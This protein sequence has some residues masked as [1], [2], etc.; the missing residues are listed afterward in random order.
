MDN[1][2]VRNTVAKLFSQDREVRLETLKEVSVADVPAYD[3]ALVYF[4]RSNPSIEEKIICIRSFHN[5]DREGVLECIE[6]ASSDDYYEVRLVAFKR[7]A[8]LESDQDLIKYS[9]I[10]LKGLL[11]S[12][13]E[14]LAFCLEIFQGTKFKDKLAQVIAVHYDQNETSSCL[15]VLF[16]IYELGLSD[17]LFVLESCLNHFE[18]S[19]RTYAKKLLPSYVNKFPHLKDLQVR[20]RVTTSEDIDLGQLSEVL[21]DKDIAKVVDYLIKMRKLPKE[22]LTNE[23]LDCLLVHL[24]DEINPFIIATIIKTLPCF[25]NFKAYDEICEFL[26]HE[27]QR[28]VANCV[29]C[30][31]EQDDKRVLEF[32]ALKIAHLDYSCK[33]DLRIIS[34]AMTV[35]RRYEPN[36]ALQ[37]MRG[38]TV[39]NDHAVYTYL[40]DVCSW[41][42]NQLLESMFLLLNRENRVRI[43]SSLC[44]YFRKHSDLSSFKQ[45]IGLINRTSDIEKRKVLIT[46][47]RELLDKYQDEDLPV[48]VDQTDPFYNDLLPSEKVK[49]HKR[50]IFVSIVGVLII[51]IWI[52]YI[53]PN[54][55]EKQQISK[56]VALFLSIGDKAKLNF[57][58]VNQDKQFFYVEY[59]GNYFQLLKDSHEDF[60][61]GD[62]VKAEVVY[63][64][65]T[66]FSAVK[67]LKVLSI[68]A[69]N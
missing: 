60:I 20:S 50:L 51:A 44:E 39:A 43:V 30:L 64:K 65:D 53:V 34:G 11:D 17:Q 35:L 26:L 12:H 28:V 37:Y 18:E 15:A 10:L 3:K 63:L 14:N 7:V 29:E 61:T 6:E 58:I 49:F 23:V 42:D 21:Q 24:R 46:C 62:I 31:S 56:P 40:H 57:K 48:I 22:T 38:L 2:I 47:Y 1:D 69:V 54:T 27:D 52:A 13:I 16:L 66:K 9:Y 68:Q 41:D 55:V 59:N 32:I 33:E 19:V 4:F 67:I 36:L 25:Q 5:F 8:K 45:F